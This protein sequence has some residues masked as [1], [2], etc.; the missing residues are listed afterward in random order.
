MMVWGYFCPD[1]QSEWEGKWPILLDA[2]ST[3]EYILNKLS[4]VKAEG[5]TATLKY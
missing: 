2:T 1:L 4:L 3:L 5:E